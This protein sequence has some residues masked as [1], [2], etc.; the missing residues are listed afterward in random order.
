MKY[1]SLLT[2]TFSLLQSFFFAQEK[3]DYKGQSFLVYPH[4]KEATADYIL[5]GAINKKNKENIKYLYKSMYDNAMIDEEDLEFDMMGFEY[6]M[7]EANAVKLKKKERKSIRENAIYYFETNEAIYQN[8]TPSI[9]PLPDGKYVQF[10]KNVFHLSPEGDIIPELKQAA[11]F[12]E[13]K[14]NV[15]EGFAYW[16][17][18]MGD[19][20]EQ[21]YFK[22]GQKTGKW[23]FKRYSSWSLLGDNKSVE[24]EAYEIKEFEYVDGLHNGPYTLMNN[25]KIMAKGNYLKGEPSGEWFKFANQ[26]IFDDKGHFQDMKYYLKEHFTYA[27]EDVPVVK[28]ILIRDQINQNLR[29]VDS[30]SMPK[31]VY[32]TYINFN[33]MYKY[34]EPKE[35]E[36]ELPEEKITSYDGEK[37]DGMY[38]DEFGG[39]YEGD[40]QY[41]GRQPNVYNGR[42]YVNGKY[43]SKNKYIDSVGIQFKYKDVYEEY[44]SNGNLK[45]RYHFKDGKLLSEDSVFWDNGKVANTV[46][47]DA[48]KKEYYC[49]TYDYEG[50]K[51][52]SINYD[53]TGAFIKN[54]M[55]EIYKSIEMI[56][57]IRA[58]KR[59]DRGVNYFNYANWDTLIERTIV[60]PTVLYKSWYNDKTLCSETKFNPTTHEFTTVLNS[61]KGNLLYKRVKTYGEDYTYYT[62]ATDAYLGDLYAKVISN[63]NY[64]GYSQKDTIIHA[65]AYYSRDYNETEDYTLFYKGKNYEGDIVINMDQSKVNL[66]ISEKSLTID[67]PSNA[68]NWKIYRDYVKYQKKGH[69]KYDKHFQNLAL[70]VNYQHTLEDI[71]PFL[72][73]LLAEL[74][75]NPYGEYEMEGVRGFKSNEV[76]KVVGA[77]KNGKP[78]GLWTIY[79]AKGRIKR[80]VS[81]DNGEK[82]GEEK[83]YSVAEPIKKPKKGKYSE[84]DY[85]EY[86]PYMEQNLNLF[87]YPEKEVYY[88]SQISNYNKGIKNG[89]EKVYQWDGSTIYSGNYRDG[90]LDG[91]VVDRNN[92]IVN[93]ESYKDGLLDGVSQTKLTLPGKDTITLFDLNFQNHQLQGE[94]KSYHPSGKLAKR[95]FFLNNEPIDDYEAYDTLGF[96]YHYVKFLYSFPIEEKIWEENE[97]SVRYLFDWQDS[98]NFRPNDLLDIPSAYD[99]LME[100]G[101]MDSYS[102]EQ[103]YYGRPSLIDKTGIKYHVTKYFPDQIIS[104]DGPIKAGKK[105]GCWYY[106]NYAGRKL[107]EIEYF[108]TILV[109]ND[110]IKF[111]AKGIRTDLDSLGNPLHTSWVIEKIENYD[112]SHTDHYEVRQFMTIW[113]KDKS[114]NRMNGYVKNYYDDGTLQSEGNMKNGLPT[115]IWKYYT[116]NG[117]LHQVG[118]YVMGKRNGRW[119]KGDL[120]KTNYLGDICMNPNLP[121]LERR[122]E[123]QE[124]MLDIN[125]RY[126]HLGKIISS[127]FYDI[128][129]NKK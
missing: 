125:I 53:S 115:G 128:N 83:T 17:N 19:T 109:V 91:M 88:V 57:G 50:K 7:F 38:L 66:K 45:Y 116:P 92:L 65:K 47:Y 68:F 27:D 72:N 110:S 104:R 31:D 75:Y 9:D 95:G 129:N 80:Q 44:Y 90:Y 42:V 96:K 22:N 30:V 24:R 41:K 100:Y 89:P 34:F 73:S 86:D 8:I 114:M 1:L 113:E 123:F 107:Y 10:Y 25:G 16:I 97:L 40:Y 98:I 58:F 112:C 78:S 36:L 79:D 48:A 26:A 102:L 28:Q 13:L 108:D 62:A 63:A 81:Y 15:L 6:E 77:F 106:N 64:T 70:S 54:E 18:T 76:S 14:N 46:T 103:P 11:G 101:L 117:Q 85:Y 82:Q 99:L 124:N 21:G 94:S 119:L 105:V 32:Q 29:S 55:F 84:W 71:F 74:N 111:K 61:I 51:A 23:I 120:S 69:S 37:S 20:V 43:I 56:D 33:F 127:E 12:F 121:D 52:Y 3:F 122:I 49:T 60:Q 67:Y 35:E 59:L 5:F 4:R 93:Y 39:E 118:E 87:D 126:F 2:V